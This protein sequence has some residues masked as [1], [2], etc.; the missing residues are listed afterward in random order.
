MCSTFL[1]ASNMFKPVK[2]SLND[3]A[4]ILSS[5]GGPKQAN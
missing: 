4:S 5:D 3:G 1:N 2:L